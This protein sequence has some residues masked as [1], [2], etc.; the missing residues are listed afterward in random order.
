MGVV[1]RLQGEGCCFCFCAAAEDSEDLEIGAVESLMLEFVPFL[2][3]SPFMSC[4]CCPTDCS[5]DS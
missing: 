2:L 1:G 5:Y 3:C 4:P